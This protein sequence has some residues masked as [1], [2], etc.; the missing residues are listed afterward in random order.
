MSVP[1]YT[2]GPLLTDEDAA[3][4]IATAAIDVAIGMPSDRWSPASPVAPSASGRTGRW[5]AERLGA[6][7]TSGS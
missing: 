5:P 1:P 7:A 4:R 2:E 6:A 3:T